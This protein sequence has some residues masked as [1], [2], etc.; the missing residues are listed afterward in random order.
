MGKLTYPIIYITIS[1]LLGAS[2]SYIFFKKTL[3]AVTENVAHTNSSSSCNYTQSKLDGFPHVK[4]VLLADQDCESI[5]LNPLKNNLKSLIE[6]E[7][8]KGSVL[9]ASVYIRDLAGDD[10]ISVFGNE[11]YHPASMNKVGVLI[12]F[13]HAAESYPNLLDQKLTFEKHDASLPEQ[14]YTSKGLQPGTE[15]SVKDLLHY[16]IAYSDNEATQLLLGHIDANFYA[17][18]FTD[19]GL[20]KPSAIFDDSKVTAKEYS[21]FMRVLYNASYLSIPASEFAIKL[22]TECDFKEGLLKTLPKELQVSHK[23]GE[24]RTD[25]TYELHESGIVYLSNKPYLI[26]I[27]TK[28]TERKPL[29]DIIG[30]ISGMVYN[31]FN[32]TVAAL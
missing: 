8:A 4:P 21:V 29:S 16:M 3:G 2:L 22:L 25:N 10:W 23:F 20:P 1:A 11:K 19:L 17:K 32:T 26:T 13:L 30:A 7:Q 6:A 5:K 15:Y 12:T 27:M 31:N 28:G 9:S 24:C 14:Y 18:T